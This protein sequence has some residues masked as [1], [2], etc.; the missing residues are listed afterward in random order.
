MKLANHTISTIG[1][2]AAGFLVYVALLAHQRGDET[3][4]MLC[5]VF[6]AISIR[7]AIM[8]DIENAK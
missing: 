5:W 7:T 3:G 6:A 8:L 1:A 2:G 4:S